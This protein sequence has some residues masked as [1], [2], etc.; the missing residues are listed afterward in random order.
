MK[1][2]ILI[3]GPCSAESY[4][5]LEKTYLEI[6]NNVKEELFAFRAGVWKPRTNPNEFE[7]NGEEALKWLKKIKQKYKTP[8]ATE[9]GNIKHVKLALK[10][11]VDVLWIGART[12]SNPFLIQEIAE[13]IKKQGRQ[14][15]KVFIKNPINPELKLWLGAFGRF[16]NLGINNL[17]AIHRG[18]NVHHKSNYRNDPLWQIMIDFKKARPNTQIIVDP[19][20]ICG[21]RELLEDIMVESLTYHPNGFMIETHYNPEIAQSDKDQQLKPKDLA[22]MMSKVKERE[23]Q[24][25]DPTFNSQISSYRSMIDTLDKIV[26]ETLS[27]RFELSKKIGDLKKDFN[28]NTFQEKRFDE[29]M[30]SRT[31]IGKQL[32]LSEDFIKE[33]FKSIH[34]ESIERQK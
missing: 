18:F 17:Y 2:K 22:S 16:E 31:L 9:V 13:T 27:K 33:L 24:S 8:I 19:S 30:E 26:L 12:T 6:K 20:H 29:V 11:N 34:Q 7:G 10:Y 5:Q 25:S 15:I 4:E 14:D 32:N 23:D 3:L 28:V 21:K 1:N